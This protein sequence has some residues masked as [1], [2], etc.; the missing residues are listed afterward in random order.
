M[1]VHRK[2]RAASL[3][4]PFGNCVE[5]LV[6]VLYGIN[7][8][9]LNCCTLFVPFMKILSIKAL[10]NNSKNKVGIFKELLM[11]HQQ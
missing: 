2:V 3:Q 10:G 5:G 6:E 7:I 9:E 8:T 1:Q 11:L 4:T